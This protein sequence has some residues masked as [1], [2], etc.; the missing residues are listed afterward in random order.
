MKG[1]DYMIKISG[2]S[3]LQFLVI[4]TRTTDD[5]GSEG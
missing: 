3:W 4:M 5:H 1:S 2:S